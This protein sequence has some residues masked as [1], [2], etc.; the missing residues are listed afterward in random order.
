MF[1]D[2]IN[3][4]AVYKKNIISIKTNFKMLYVYSKI[5]LN[6]NALKSCDI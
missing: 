2:S 3:C 1:H 6:Q 4:Q 5:I